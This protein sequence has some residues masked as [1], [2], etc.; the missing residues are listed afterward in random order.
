MNVIK[1]AFLSLRQ[2]FQ[3][4]SSTLFIIVLNF[5][6]RRCPW[7][8]RYFFFLIYLRFLFSTSFISLEKNRIWIEWKKI[9]TNRIVNQKKT[10]FSTL[11]LVMIIVKKKKSLP[12]S[13]FNITFLVSCIND[14]TKKSI[15]A[16]WL[17]LSLTIVIYYSN[18]MLHFYNE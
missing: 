4:F 17:S 5:H 6:S 12:Y 10:N 2:C 8:Q 14:F 16:F 13:W 9:F 1:G 7:W 11:R 15:V 3:C 18:I